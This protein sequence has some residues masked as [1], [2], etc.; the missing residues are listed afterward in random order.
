MKK[1]T[2]IGENFLLQNDTARRLYHDYAREMPVI[3]YHCHLPVNQIDENRNF[4]NLTDIWLR[5][6]HYKWR[7]MRTLGV[8][9]KYIT[10]DAPDE[11]KFRR[12]AA[13]SPYTVRSPL[14]HWTQME[15]KDPFGIED[16]LCAENASAVYGH[17]NAL[18]Q[19]PE[20]SARGLL[21]HFRVTTVCTT[22][23][24]CDDLR[25]HEHLAASD[26]TTRVLPAFR[27]DK[28]LRLDGGPAFRTYLD[29]LGDA[30]GVRIHGLDT[31][32]EALAKR[33]DY[34]HDRGGRLSDH[35]LNYIPRFDPHDAGR[36]E[37]DLAGVLQGRSVSPEAQDNYAGYVLF[38]LCRMY[39][40][41]GWVQQFHLGALRNT[42][43]RKLGIYG[44]DTGFDSIGDYPQAAGMAALFDQLE[45]SE[46]LAKTI[47]YNLN[48]AD[49]EVFASMVGNFNEGPSRGK[50]QYG[51]AWWFLDQLDGME[52]QINA[53]SQIGILSCFV[54]MLTDSRSFLSYSRHE[55][56]RRLLCNIF[57]KDI[58][59]GYLPN[60]EKWIGSIIQDIC[61]HNARQYFDW[62]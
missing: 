15:L 11:E 58:E 12:W 19:Q 48:P 21:S 2:F 32:L 1:N 5:G 51:A 13:I 3:D 60:D 49:N 44:P 40:R 8:A 14:F 27:P 61:Y 9:E 33:V 42:N 4:N 52:K 10:G 29:R 45:Q 36:V 34:F 47:L 56:F 43:T 37:K 26:F 6:D 57:G 18:L 16:L 23:D 24:P 25:H 41:K 55:Y 7:A 20:Y 62:P 53:L 39:H 54:G 28:V 17:C 31:L 50:M 30:A 59:A 38:Q 22:D 35:G 46:E